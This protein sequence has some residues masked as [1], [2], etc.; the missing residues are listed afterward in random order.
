MTDGLDK[1]TR[2]GNGLA[3]CAGLFR[4]TPAAEKT[5]LATC[6]TIVGT[7]AQARQTSQGDAK[8]LLDLD[9]RAR[10]VALAEHSPCRPWRTAEGKTLPITS[11]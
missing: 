11:P 6:Y 8:A 7:T 4:F 10:S 3:T 1:V 5:F 9:K 2:N